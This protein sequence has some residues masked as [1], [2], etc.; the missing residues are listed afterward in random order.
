MPAPDFSAIFDAT[1]SPY[2]VLDA[3]L[4]IVSV[5]KAYLRATSTVHGQL[6]GQHMFDAF[7]D[8]PDDPEASGVENLRASLLR[9][10]HD[11]SVDTMAI[12]K[13]DIRVT[14]ADGTR[15]EERYWS[16]I[17]TPV[18]DASGNISHIIHRVED[19]TD[20]V[21]SRNR[22]VSMAA[23][24]Q[25]Q[26][27]EIEI[28][29]RRLREA[30][31]KLEERV[32]ARTEAQRRV[33]EKLRASEQRFRT[34]ADSIPQIVWIV[35]AAGRGIYFNKQWVTYTG[36]DLNDTTPKEVADEFVH[37]D[38]C[39]R[40][41]DAWMHARQ[42]GQTFGVEHRIRSATG[43]YHWFLVRAEPYRDTESGDIV[44]WF[45]TST[46]VDDRKLAEDALRESDR[47][48]DEF[49]A[50]LAHELRNPLAPIAAAADLLTLGRIDEARIRQTSGIIK[51]QVGHMTGL[52]DDLLDVS[53]VT[54]GRVKLDK[55]VLDAKK[56]LYDAVEQVRPLIELR[57][58][59][60][61][62]Q[63]S[64]EAGFVCGDVKRLVQVIANLLNN[65]AK[66]TQ[67]G[68]EIV[69][70]M[71][72]DGSHVRVAVS[73]NGIGIAPELQPTVFDLF[74]Q[75]ERASDRSQGGLGI[76]LALVKSLVELHGGHVT[77]HS[78]GMGKGSCFV[79]CLPGVNVDVVSPHAGQQRGVP[80][81]PGKMLKVLIVDDNADAAQ[82]LGMFIEELGHEVVIEHHPERAIERARAIAPEV[83][84]LDIGLPDMDGNELAGWLRRQPETA[85]SVLI[86]VTGYGQ[87]RDRDT[88]F[89]AG[90][91]HYFAK[92]VDT[93]KLVSLLS[94]IGKS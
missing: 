83:C 62:V 51:R 26:E 23:K 11:K 19:I 7:P 65:A 31:D 75:A 57:R 72:V 53:R 92:P 21:N 67:E 87:D 25:D 43:E 34:M 55:T 24:I 52:V 6:I 86:A 61:S 36:V 89:S 78:E 70:A 18:F 32:A 4:R 79:V 74:T 66:Y 2:L 48:K 9:V 73:D 58:H 47:R 44:L 20:F 81:Q 69:L 8:N 38:D 14:G 13:Y 46:D 80:A 64:P 93:A 5:N 45:G 76:G 41:L 84:L 39:A 59:R 12:Q 16:P 82:M 27:L 63:T 28:A 3:E 1:P 77:V 94:A 88:A 37:P 40:T 68:G 56:I 35:D 29:N 22:S 30:K 60:L 33:E 85:H 91:D 17:N 15:F 42:N 50:M 49:L 10:L 54:R 90:F 71:D